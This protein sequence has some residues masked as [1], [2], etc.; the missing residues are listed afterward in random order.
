MFP[1]SFFPPVEEVEE[2]EERF[3][4]SP[5]ILLAGPILAG[6]E[7]GGLFVRHENPKVTREDIK[8]ERR[9]HSERER[10]RERLREQIY[11]YK[12]RIR[13][14][15]GLANEQRGG[16]RFVWTLSCRP[17]QDTEQ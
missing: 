8:K 16:C 12:T 11:I 4:R 10:E 6:Q 15:F 2:E 7:A 17:V 9:T 14:R 5:L 13:H 3:A 1:S